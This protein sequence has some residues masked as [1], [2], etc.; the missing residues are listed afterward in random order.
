MENISTTVD[1]SEYDTRIQG[2]PQQHE[3]TIQYKPILATRITTM[4]TNTTCSRGM[5]DTGSSGLKLI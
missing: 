4:E 3:C 1:D 5:N 2:V